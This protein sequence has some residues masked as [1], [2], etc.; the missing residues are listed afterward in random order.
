[1]GQKPKPLTHSLEHRRTW[2][3]RRFGE[4]G[5][6]ALGRRE[7]LA[8]IVWPELERSYEVRGSTFTYRR[9]TDIEAR[10]ER[11]AEIFR[12]GAD[13][14]VG[15]PEIEWH[16]DPRGLVERT[17][18]GEWGL[19][20]IFLGNELIGA[21]SLHLIRGDAAIEWVWACVDPP[22]RGRGAVRRAGEFNDLVVAQSGAELGLVWVVTTHR[23][24]QM[25]AEQA[26]YVPMGCLVGKRLYGGSDGRY[27]RHTLILYGKLYGEGK[28]HLQSWESMTLT[29][30]A[31]RLVEVV[32]GMWKEASG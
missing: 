13:E 15:N 19:Y 29:P 14:M 21:E 4:L 2:V 20:G 9:L 18:T 30:Q 3:R 10:A 28:T 5:D 25:A 22:Y 11:V 8:L 1:M 16:Q 12:R 24:T 6:T 23:Y 31:S 26:G 32:R 17:R 27:Y 7:D